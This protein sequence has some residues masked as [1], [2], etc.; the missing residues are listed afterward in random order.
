MTP[1]LSALQACCRGDWR[2]GADE[3]TSAI[4]TPPPPPPPPTTT[5]ISASLC[6]TTYLCSSTGSL[7]S[8]H[9]NIC[10]PFVAS[11]SGEESAA[12][13]PRILP[14]LYKLMISLA[15][16]RANHTLPL[17]A[18]MKIWRVTFNMF[19]GSTSN[20]GGTNAYLWCVLCVWVYPEHV[21]E[22]SFPVS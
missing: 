13:E 1:L 22:G 15:V 3:R 18:K 20:S 5:P 9:S 8:I 14:F 11:H 7:T 17:Q 16:A 4:T 6:P 12:Y 2:K 19:R 21:T 10:H